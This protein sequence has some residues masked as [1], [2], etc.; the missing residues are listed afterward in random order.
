MGAAMR[1]VWRAG[2][3]T[4]A[5]SC[6]SSAA[7]AQLRE[8]SDSRTVGVTA[9]FGC[10]VLLGGL[11]AAARAFIDGH[12]P[13]RA[14]AIG[15]IGG[16]VHF[17]AKLIGP[18]TSLAGVALGATG[19]AIVVNAGRG[20]SPLEELY[21]PVGPMR[22]RVTPRAP[23]K[24]RLTVNV[25]NTLVLARSLAWRGLVVDW[26]RTASTGTV[27]FRTDGRHIVFD[28]REAHGMAMGPFIVISAFATDPARTTKHELVHAHQYWFTDEAV[29][30]PVEEY[31]R[32]GIPGVRRLPPWLELGVV[33]PAL[34][35]LERG[36]VGREGPVFRVKESEAEI[37]AR[38]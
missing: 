26:G 36:L 12:D 8:P 33:S 15:A 22:L 24:L 31:L 1:R 14:F 20:M 32:A 18:G 34:S 4:V 23:G 10:N 6:Y 30:R 29:G 13:A 27:A 7:A 9:A 16:A 2:L 35:M 28:D 3:T 38:P 5:L 21:L 37:L 25:V 17:G 19:T 11:T